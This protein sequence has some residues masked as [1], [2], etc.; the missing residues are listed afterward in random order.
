MRVATLERA[1]GGAEPGAL[2]DEALPAVRVSLAC[3]CCGH[4]FLQPIEF[5]KAYCRR[6]SNVWPWE[7][8]LRLLTR[9]VSL[10]QGA[11]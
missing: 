9:K 4:T 5:P 7:K 11:Q 3:P 1:G 10:A 6:C 8:Q 2:K